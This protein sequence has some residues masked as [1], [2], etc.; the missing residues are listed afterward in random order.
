M[1][2]NM[3]CIQKQSTANSIV[4]NWH[5]KGQGPLKF[6]TGSSPRTFKKQRNKPNIPVVA[7]M[8]NLLLYMQFTPNLPAPSV[9]KNFGK[10]SQIYQVHGRHRLGCF[11]GGF[12]HSPES[13]KNVMSLRDKGVNVWEE[14][15]CDVRK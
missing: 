10:Q 12:V 8:P 9:S 5:R 4:R 15:K 13:F 1:V 3:S 6:N 2:M 7:I 11:W 14:A